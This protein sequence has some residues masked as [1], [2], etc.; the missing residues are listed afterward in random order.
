MAR[1]TYGNI[2]AFRSSYIWAIIPRPFVPPMTGAGVTLPGAGQQGSG[3]SQPEG[4]DAAASLTAAG[5]ASG[6]A[7]LRVPLG[8]QD[9]DAAASITAAGT[10]SR[11]GNLNVPVDDH[12]SKLK[13]VAGGL[14]YMK[15]IPYLHFFIVPYIT[16]ARAGAFENV[17]EALV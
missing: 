8:H 12:E 4:H 16:G 9:L 17:S 2:R 7:Q 1:H 11:G 6:G 3:A 13:A 14:A 5:A 15:L 10:A